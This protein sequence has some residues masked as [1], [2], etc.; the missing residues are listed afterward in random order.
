MLIFPMFTRSSTTFLKPSK[1]FLRSNEEEEYL[2]MEP[3]E[4]QYAEGKS[5]NQEAQRAEVNVPPAPRRLLPKRSRD[6][7]PDSVPNIPIAGL[8]IL[9][10]EELKYV[11]PAQNPKTSRKIQGMG[12][13]QFHLS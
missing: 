13:T 3:I 9:P 7:T 5:Q 11:D 6:I 1:I 8:P 2:L 4:Q 12:G 10:S